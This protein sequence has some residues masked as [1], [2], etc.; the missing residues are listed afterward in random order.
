MET[1]TR[2]GDYACPFCGEPA[3][4]VSNTASYASHITRKRMCLVCGMKHQTVETRV[5]L[6]SILDFAHNIT[7]QAELGACKA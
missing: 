7:K 4:I 5:D 3:T 2:Y 6:M 1:P